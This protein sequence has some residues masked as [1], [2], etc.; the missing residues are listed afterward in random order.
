MAKIR[1]IKAHRPLFDA[2][3]RYVLDYGGRGSGKSVGA[4]QAIITRALQRRGRFLVV[5]K[6]ARTLRLSVFPRIRAELSDLGILDRCQV[7]KQDMTF[8]LPN[9]SEINCIGLDDAE[10]IKSI[11]EPCGAW[12]EEADSL[13][14]VDF[15]AV[16]FVLRQGGDVILMTFNPPP[17]VPGSSHWIKARFI[18]RSDPA[19][20]V[21]KTT[22]QDNP[23]LP[24]AYVDRLHALK[25]TNPELYR[26]WALG[27]FVGL[28]GA[29][30]TNWG[31]VD[32]IPGDATFLGYGLDFGFSVDP[33]ALIASYRYNGEFYHR[34]IVYQTDL[35]N[36]DLATVMRDN[37]V[38]FRDEIRADSAEPKSIEELRREGFFVVPAAKGPD[39]VRAGLD[40]MRGFRHNVERGSTGLI[41]EFGSYSWKTDRDGKPKPQPIDDFNHGIDAIRYRLYDGPRKQAFIGRA[42]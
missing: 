12:I 31:I 22:W 30:F 16:D 27:E 38:T 41:K 9:G 6:V 8:H 14:E 26:M 7:N 19:A 28:S 34:E 11:E 21:I 3:S 33:A 18:D 39:S 4:S 10:K 40:Y 29:V 5:R 1:A 15:D 2:E 42:S 36:R 13:S 24:Q 25:E 20:T 17:M 32:A 23:F 35:T 37:G